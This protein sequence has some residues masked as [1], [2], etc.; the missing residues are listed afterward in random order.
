MKIAIILVSLIMIIQEAEINVNSSDTYHSL[1][2]CPDR[3]NC[4]STLD[5]GSS[6]KM[7]AIK[8]SVPLEDARAILI[9]LLESIPNCDV[10]V[11]NGD[12]LKAVF[13]SRIF[14]FKDDV[15]FLFNDRKKI[16]NFKSSSRLGYYD[17][18]VNRNRME[19]ITEQLKMRFEKPK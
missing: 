11:A 12:Y 8:Y 2:P 13:N 9:D 15:E 10:T 18:G 7:P 1:N 5:E 16:L 4:V 17:F 3:P 14:R 19:N 6:R